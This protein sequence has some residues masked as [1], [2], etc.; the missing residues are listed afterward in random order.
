MIWPVWTF[1]HTAQIF[2][3][4]IDGGTGIKSCCMIQPIICEYCFHGWHTPEGGDLTHCCLS[5]HRIPYR[6]WWLHPIC[7][8]DIIF[9]CSHFK[10]SLIISLL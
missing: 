9:H 5:R 4:F 2:E 8:S 1:L 10:M 7:L 3:K 6:S